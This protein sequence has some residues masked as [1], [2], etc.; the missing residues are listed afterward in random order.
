MPRFAQS[1]SNFVRTAGRLISQNRPG[2]AMLV[3]PQAPVSPPAATAFR[4]QLIDASKNATDKVR[5][6]LGKIGGELADGAMNDPSDDPVFTLTLTGT[7]DRAVFC[8]LPLTYTGN[9]L[10]TPASAGQILEGDSVP[11]GTASTSEGTTTGWA[12]ISIGTVHA[13][14]DGS[15]LTILTPQPVRGDVAFTRTGNSTEFYDKTGSAE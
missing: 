6:R 10:W 11:A 9:G 13:P 4:L 15:G 2:G 5:V 7:G 3:A 12:Y 14:G 1:F 8:K